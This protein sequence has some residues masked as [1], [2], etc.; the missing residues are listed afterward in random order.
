MYQPLSLLGTPGTGVPDPA[1]PPLS[2][3]RGPAEGSANAS[4]SF[5]QGGGAPVS[6]LSFQ[7]ILNQSL[8]NQS[9]TG[10]NAGASPFAPVYVPD[11]SPRPREPERTGPSPE[12]PANI[13]GSSQARPADSSDRTPGPGRAESSGGAA[14]AAVSPPDESGETAALGH[15]EGLGGEKT[16]SPDSPDLKEAEKNAAGLERLREKAGGN[17]KRAKTGPEHFSR[18]T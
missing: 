10:Q 1:L 9:L 5:P 15:A 7:E 2:L 13:G 8:T 18:R 12:S 14:A 11:Q 17:K 16:H 4:L 6:G 3:L